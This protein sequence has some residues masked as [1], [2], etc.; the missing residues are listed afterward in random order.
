MKAIVF[1]KIKN[2]KELI[3]KDVVVPKPK[4]K[5]VLV[6]V[7]AVSLNAA[8][9]RSYQMGL[10]PKKKIFGSDI[11]GTVIEVGSLCTLFKPGDHVMGDLSSSGFGGLAEFAVGKENSFI[12]KPTHLSFEQASAIPMAAVTALQALKMNK[13]MIPN[14]NILIHGSG[15][16]VGS[17][18]ILLA[19]HYRYHVT[20]VCGP[21]NMLLAKQLGADHVI[22]YLENDVTSLNKSYDL[23]LAINGKQKFKTYRRLMN[24]KATCVVVGGAISQLIKTLLFK[25][26][27]SFYN[28]KLYSLYARP[29]RKDLTFV[30]NLISNQHIS[31]I[32]DQVLT[33]QDAPDAIKTLIKGHAKGKV[34]IQIISS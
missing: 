3:Y 19:K 25:H 27:F 8:D 15:G 30:T 34:V 26:F 7:H 28:K 10:M 5:E 2:K 16:G 20:A 13:H 6:K 24:N 31:L 21:N 18:A 32:I 12:L 4:P 29:N 23:I 33:L 1:E 14:Q 17:F 11:S 9:Y 22:N